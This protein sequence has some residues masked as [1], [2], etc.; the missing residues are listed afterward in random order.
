M[1]DVNDS[2][3]QI[4]SEKDY[5]GFYELIIPEVQYSDAGKFS[6][7]ASNKYGSA[8]CE[9][10]VTVVEDKNVFGE[11]FGKIL[12]AGE[13]PL[14]RWKRNGIEFDPEERFKGML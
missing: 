10:K 8:N 13:Q 2:H 5:L 7:T 3:I 9:A 4:N 14:F 1:I 11:N 12:P 6:C